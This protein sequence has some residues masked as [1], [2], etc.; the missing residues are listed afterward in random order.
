M[1]LTLTNSLSEESND[2][3]V[4]TKA[5]EDNGNARRTYGKQDERRHSESLFEVGRTSSQ[6]DVSSQSGAK[7]Q[8]STSRNI[9]DL[10]NWISSSDDDSF[11]RDLIKD[12][13]PKRQG[14]GQKSMM[15]NVLNSSPVIERY[16]QPLES[17][18][19][20]YSPVRPKETT[21]VGNEL[22]NKNP[23]ARIEFSDPISSSPIPS[24]F[25]KS[26]SQPTELSSG[27]GSK[28]RK[29]P[30]HNSKDGPSIKEWREANKVTRKKEDILQEMVIEIALKL[31]DKIESEYFKEVFTLPTVR[32]TYFEL[33]MV[34]WKRRIKAR[35]DRDKDIFVPCEPTE[36]SERVVVVFYETEDLINAI[37]EETL[38]S[39]VKRIRQRVTMEDPTLNYHLLVMVGGYREYLRKL[40]AAEHR[41]YKEQ[42]LEKM[43]DVS[44][45]KKARTKPNITALEVQ[46]LVME[47]EVH[48]RINMF[49]PKSMEETVDWLHSFTY[50]IGASLYDKHERNS[51]FANL[52]SV[53]LGSDQKSTFIEMIK[54]FNLMTNQKAEKLY[55]F[56]T[57]VGAIYNRLSQHEDLGKVSGKSIVP[58]TVNAAMKKLFRATDP[59][60]VI[61]D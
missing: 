32:T 14:R 19:E 46:R 58:P 48:M 33:P 2:N 24:S 51:E 45:G 44:K 39:D 57:S 31:K 9:L 50:T 1:D 53:K 26:V 40:Q 12:V 61:V 6:I 60:E 7:T 15:K 43:L 17:I 11:T 23:V 49:F 16:S 55:E 20:S 47:T 37:R 36:V 35:Y 5:A 30:S 52:G 13:T 56:Y 18:P 59:N 42:M 8:V 10:N 27:P 28:R 54:K 29:T 21:R 3:S 22:I 25:P 4:A 41:M 34:S 38:E